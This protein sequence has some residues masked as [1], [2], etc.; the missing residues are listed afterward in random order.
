MA[1]KDINQ[2]NTE[3]KEEKVV[4]KPKKKKLTGSQ[5]RKLI[6]KVMGWI[7]AIAMIVGSLLSIFGLLIYR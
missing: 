5:K 7:M 4:I 2:E 3:E 1:K 6:M